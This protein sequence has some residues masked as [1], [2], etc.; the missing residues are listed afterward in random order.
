MLLA[1]PAKRGSQCGAAPPP[2]ALP[3]KSA[4][5]IRQ[6]RIKEKLKNFK[7]LFYKSQMAYPVDST[8]LLVLS[9]YA[10]KN[11]NR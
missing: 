3:K 8:R 4:R 1:R 7:E 5:T 2:A 10:I 9:E 11:S 6:R